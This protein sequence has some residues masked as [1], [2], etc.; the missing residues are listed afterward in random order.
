MSRIVEKSSREN[1]ILSFKTFSS[2]KSEWKYKSD[3]VDNE[4]EDTVAFEMMNRFIFRPDLTMAASGL[5][6]NEV[7]TIPHLLIMVSEAKTEKFP[8]PDV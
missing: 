3:L 8:K 1:K 5:T 4:Q 6:G 2:P 7:V